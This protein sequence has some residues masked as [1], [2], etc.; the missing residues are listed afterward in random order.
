MA[1]YKGKH[2]K[3]TISGV[4]IAL[5]NEASIRTSQRPTWEESVGKATTDVVDGTI[6][7]EWSCTR[8]LNNDA[9]NGELFRDLE[10][11]RNDFNLLLEINGVDNTSIV[12]SSCRVRDYEYN[13]GGAND[14]ITE[15]ISGQA[16]NY[17][18]D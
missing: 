16:I 11:N 15:R 18:K 8:K 1:I 13:V 10:L 5:G 4:V 9:T 2:A 6:Q 14:V 12:A 17:Y 3:I 7:V